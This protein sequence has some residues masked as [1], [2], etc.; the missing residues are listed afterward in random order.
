[1]CVRENLAQ[2]RKE[3]TTAC[4]RSGRDPREVRLVAVAK[5]KTADLIREAWAAGQK[6]IGESYV[7]EFVDKTETIEEPV[8]WHFVGSLQTNKVKLLCGKVALIHSVD[9]LHLAE[10][11][12]RQWGKTEKTADILIQLNLGHETTKSGTSEEDLETLVRK[13]GLLP[14]IRIRGLM[15]LPPYFDDPEEVRPF[16]RRLR[17]LARYID[18][19]GIERVEMHEL[20]MG[21]THDF[22]VAIEEGATLIRVGTAIFGTRQLKR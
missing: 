20:S 21:M 8:E 22:Q 16:F 13:I 7:Q 10:E 11:I 9:R 18:S 3:M 17:E 12:D 19:M 15:T 1:M 6:V 14:H 2:V 4:L 5:T